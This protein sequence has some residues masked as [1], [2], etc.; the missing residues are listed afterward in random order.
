MEIRN[1]DLYGLCGNCGKDIQ[2]FFGQSVFDKQLVWHLSYDCPH[3]GEA[4]ELDDTGTLPNELR[5]AILAKEG[6][7]NF[8]VLETEERA[9]L[10]VKI[11]RAAMSLSLAEAMK[12]KKK[13]P[14]GVCSGTKAEVDRLK[15]LLDA[16]G[17]KAEIGI[18][19][20]A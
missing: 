13:M 8:T 20:I 3:C 2:M 16:E 7:W 9:T 17:L 11:L 1:G 18:N 10:A 4:I 12:L 14:G 15:Q 6:T 19:Y 5:E